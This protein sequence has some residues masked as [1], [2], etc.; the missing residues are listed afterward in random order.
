[1]HDLWMDTERLIDKNEFLKGFPKEC[2]KL[3]LPAESYNINEAFHKAV[4]K[5]SIEPLLTASTMMILIYQQKWLAGG[6]RHIVVN[7]S[8]VKLQKRRTM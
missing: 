6:N 2:E 4:N 8:F 1:M 7:T 5:W 3:N